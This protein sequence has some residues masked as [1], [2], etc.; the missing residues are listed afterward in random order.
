[1]VGPD[2]G[3][4]IPK[5]EHL[6]PR[7]GGGGDP[8]GGDS[9]G[10]LGLPTDGG[11]S[12]AAGSF[13]QFHRRRDRL[14]EMHVFQQTQQVG[15]GEP[16]FSIGTQRAAKVGHGRG[17]AATLRELSRHLLI[18][19]TVGLTE[20]LPA[21]GGLFSGLFCFEVQCRAGDSARD[22]SSKNGKA[23]GHTDAVSANE[24]L[25]QVDAARRACRDG[26]VGAITAQIIGQGI[27]AAVAAVRIAFERFEDDPVQITSQLGCK[28]GGAG[29]ISVCKLGQELMEWL[30]SHV[31]GGDQGL[32]TEE[33]K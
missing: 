15:G 7:F 1:M 20:I 17:I 31:H 26:L 32:A 19:T 8:A 13:G 22:D 18:R 4:Q 30:L 10:G 6:L 23:R 33:F 16:V 14:E 5:T 25:S 21:L 29:W 28:R 24:F 27:G 2:L 12:C 3:F 11:E 9:D